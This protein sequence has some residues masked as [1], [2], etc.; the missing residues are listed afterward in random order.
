[1]SWKSFPKVELHLHLE[2][3][4]DPAF[5][6]GLAA[7]K[8]IDIRGIFDDN[9]AYKY[10]GFTEFLAVYEAATLALKNPEDFKRLTQSVLENLAEHNVVYAETFVSPD[11]CGG[12]DLG[13]WSEYLAAMKEAH[14]DGVTLKGIVT[15]IRHFGPDNARETARCA[16]KTAGDW[17]VGFGMAGAEDAGTARDFSYAFDMAR[18]AGLRL[19]SHA[20]EWGGAQ[21]IWDT[22][23]NLKVERVGHGVHAINDPKLVDYLAETG[24]VLEVNPGSNVALGVYPSLA[25][26]PIAKLRDAGVKVTV[27]TDDPPFFN[28]TMTSEFEQL[29]HV[30]GWGVD[31]FKQLNQT[32]LEAAFCDAA[33]KDLISKRLETV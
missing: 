17:L 27:S 31:D 21:S 7:E 10:N 11:F 18:D 24:I 32:A 19:T 8:S 29:E 4:A 23:Q 5:V 1:M 14:V 2:G 28:T 3:A 30:F 15:C 6:R 22:L 33:T 9:G 20:G 12:R 16:A 25:E 13:A 26:H